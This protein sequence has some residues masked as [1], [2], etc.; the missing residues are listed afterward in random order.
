ME[1][2]KLQYA[3]IQMMPINRLKNYI[4]WKMKFDEDVAKMKKEEID[5][6]S[7]DNK[8]STRR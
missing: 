1:L 7:R 6:V 5:K 3:S 2:G 8:N 4:K